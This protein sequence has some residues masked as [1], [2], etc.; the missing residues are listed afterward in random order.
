[1]S[2]T[3]ASPSSPSRSGSGSAAGDVPSA[4]GW[5]ELR[6][7]PLGDD[8]PPVGLA[9]IHPR[10]GVALIESRRG[11]AGAVGRLRRALEARQFP[12]RFGGYPPMV[13]VVLPPD[14]ISEL[15]HVL[16]ESFRAEPRL[17]LRGGDAWTQVVRAALEA[18]PVAAEPG[19]PGAGRRGAFPWRP[20]MLLAGV[21]MTGAVAATVVTSRGGREEASGR[22]GMLAA[23]PDRAAAAPEPAAG[24]GIVAPG[25]VPASPAPAEDRIADAGPDAAAP[26]P[27]PQVARGKV[28]G[29]A[30]AASGGAAGNGVVASGE[31]PADPAPA[32]DR[33]DAG[34]D[35]AAAVRDDAP[36]SA[37][38][39]P[40]AAAGSGVV[41]SGGAPADP[42]SP[43]NRADGPGLDV[44]SAPPAADEGDAPGPA[45]PAPGAAAGSG[46]VASG[47]A[48]ADPAP[49]ENR[50]DGP[51]PDVASSPPALAGDGTPDPVA[52]APR[53]AEE[54]EVVASA[55]TPARPAPAEERAAGPKPDVAS[56]PP[57][58]AGGGAGGAGARSPAGPRGN[59]AGSVPTAGSGDDAP[60]PASPAR[61]ADRPPQV[62]AVAQPAVRRQA[63][64]QA[65]SAAAADAPITRRC[66]SIVVRSSLGEDLTRD[67][68]E[69][70][71]RGCPA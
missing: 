18:G 26:S 59:G 27:P 33:A 54:R 46:V 57:V 51:G 13:G 12:Y 67:E 23:A 68:R 35:V 44:A 4:P 49:P 58:A 70:L 69:Y 34:P 66:R 40:G 2:P 48:P 60:A 53:A 5:V 64:S 20:V 55:G 28:P 32:G 43:E 39:A 37:G 71:R 52:P 42:A 56:A 14:E 3:A 47:G 62:A 7:C 19:T 24:N 9:L 29:P 1:M 61:L 30:D 21:V 22:T 45:D 6:D 38:P 11:A 16:A 63:R 31:V 65:A 36:G 10:I 25:G 15:G 8:G 41:A 17:A 50:A